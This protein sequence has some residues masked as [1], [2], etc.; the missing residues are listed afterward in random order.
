MVIVTEDE[1]SVG[2]ERGQRGTGVLETTATW[3]CGLQHSSLAVDT[4]AYGVH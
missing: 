1:R 2:P 4:L 3:R